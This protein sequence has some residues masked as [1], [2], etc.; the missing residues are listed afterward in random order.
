MACI[1]IDMAAQ[2]VIHSQRPFQVD[3]V[4]DREIAE[5][6]P[7]QRLRPDLKRKE[8][9]A[10][11]DN[12]QTDAIDGYTVADVEFGC[13]RRLGNHQAAAGAFRPNLPYGA[14]RFDEAGE[15]SY[16]VLGA[17]DEV[18]LPG[19]MD[20]AADAGVAAEGGDRGA[21]ERLLED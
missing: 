7:L 13:Q 4:A 21:L 5:I 1:R 16:R 20:V 2:P 14:E 8:L 18:L 12:G 3:A 6:G 15:H 9:R 17:G 10:D 19:V 11:L